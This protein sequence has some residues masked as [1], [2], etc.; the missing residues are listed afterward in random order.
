MRLPT[1][2]RFAIVAS[3]SALALLAVTALVAT[4][5]ARADTGCQFARFTGQVNG[6]VRVCVIAPQGAQVDAKINSPITG[7]L[8]LS[9][10]DNSGGFRNPEVSSFGPGHQ[11]LSFQQG[12]LEPEPPIAAVLVTMN[13]NTIDLAPLADTLPVAAQELNGCL[14]R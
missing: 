5:G 2:F 8:G 3:L 4:P 11:C 6:T 10:A 9:F 14:L 1:A 13:F 12:W 7:L